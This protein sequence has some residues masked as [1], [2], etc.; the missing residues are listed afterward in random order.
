MARAA[1]GQSVP[2][3][4]WLLVAGDAPM[5]ARWAVLLVAMFTG[6]AVWNLAVIAK[7]MRKVR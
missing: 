2:E 7:L 6:F 5:D 4:A 1:T 3:G